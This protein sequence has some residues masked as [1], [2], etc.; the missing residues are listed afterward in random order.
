MSVRLQWS[1]G[2]LGIVLA[3]SFLGAG[4]SLRQ[5]DR[6]SDAE[7]QSSESTSSESISQ[8]PVDR[9]TQLAE[10]LSKATAR[11]EELDAKLSALSDKVDAQKIAVDNVVGSHSLKTQAVGE[12]AAQ[13]AE[14]KEEV[15]ETVAET[16]IND[17]QVVTKFRNAMESFKKGKYSDAVLSFNQV[18]ELYP[19]H[20]LAGSAQ[21]YAGESY[22]LMGEYKLALN[23]FGKVVSAFSESPRVASAL[24]RLSHCY[25][26]IG[27]NSES[28][29][30]A[31]LAR[32]MFFGNP[33][34]EWTGPG[35]AKAIQSSDQGLEVEPMVSSKELHGN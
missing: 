15:T 17:A 11:I 30:T 14:T 26:A 8:E 24:V 33:S 5:A 21:F 22:Y 32:D 23:E 6:G 25:G 19:E 3:A 35:N 13:K 34:L 27:N 10:A 2:F 28:L 31:A 12:L 4:C 7:D 16:A 29:R 20:I 18:A 1:A 9:M